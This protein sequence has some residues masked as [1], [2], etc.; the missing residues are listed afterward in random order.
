M[1]ILKVQMKNLVKDYCNVFSVNGK[2]AAF[3]GIFGL[4]ASFLG[5]FGYWL[6]RNVRFPLYI[7]L[8]LSCHALHFLLRGKKY[9]E[10]WTM[11]T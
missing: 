9:F 2:Y 3:G 7:L 8:G 10:V 5:N 11:E 6:S 1:Q 4:P